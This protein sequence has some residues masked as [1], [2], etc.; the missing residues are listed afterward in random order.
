MGKLGLFADKIDHDPLSIGYVPLHVFGDA[1]GFDVA[2]VAFTILSQL[3]EVIHGI[4]AANACLAKLGQPVSCQ[5]LVATNLATN[6]K[7]AL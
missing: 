4:M 6:G 1:S 7:E 3:S 5:Q 2:T